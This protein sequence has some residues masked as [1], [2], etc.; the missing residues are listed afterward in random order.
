MEVWVMLLF[1][2]WLWLF[3]QGKVELTGS[4]RRAK[5]AVI[6]FGLFVFW[7]AFQCL[8]LPASLVQILSPES[9]S[10]QSA[11]MESTMA[12]L[13]SGYMSL[14]VNVAYT[15]ESAVKS[16]CFFLIFLLAL[17]IL[18]TPERIRIFII[19]IVISGLF[20]A[21]YG[22]LMTLSGMEYSFFM[23]KEASQG[24]AT[25][26]FVNRNHLAGYLEMSLAMG[27]GMMIVSLSRQPAG[28]LREWFR[29]MIV[30]L[31]GPKARM[32]IA[33]AIMVIAL[34]LTRSR[35]GNSAFFF[36]LAIAGVIGLLGVLWMSRK[37][38]MSAYS[39]RPILVLFVSLIVIDVFI[40]GAWFGID[41]VK[42]RMEQTSFATEIRDEV[43]INTAD[44]VK[45]F[46]LT[47]SGGGTFAEVF[48]AFKSAAFSGYID[49]AHNDYLEFGSE[50]GLIG[51]T[52]LALLVFWSLIKSIQAQFLRR[53]YLMRGAGFSS[54]MGI[55]AIMI[56]SFVDFNLQIPANAALF[57]VLLAFGWI[58]RYQRN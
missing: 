50:F 13:S 57:V 17:L 10:I 18:N 3:V 1:I 19:A 56:H 23:A 24:V 32:R 7:V 58:A 27:I 37:G 48:P 47:G 28:S 40:V 38:K 5:P 34:V 21:V 52:L 11:T 25:G 43:D 4:V 8:P 12:E 51:I 15:F 36:S 35:M 2:G 30:I 22:S 41:K 6:C 20:Q 33:L 31:L 42:E 54:T 16:L 14:S 53:S 45:A 9:L 44:H 26:T 39:V 46:W 29:R 49:H 55:V